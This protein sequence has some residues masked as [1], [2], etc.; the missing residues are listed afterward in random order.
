M[1]NA[2][3][4]SRF[5]SAWTIGSAQSVAENGISTSLSASAIV[6]VGRP[7][8]GSMV[9]SIYPTMVFVKSNI[10]LEKAQIVTLGG[11]A[12]AG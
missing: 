6:I 12:G 8:V 9:A 1:T 3:T 10:V 5:L 11:L 7:V 2:S 4:G